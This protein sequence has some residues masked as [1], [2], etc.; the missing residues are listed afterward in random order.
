MF[1]FIYFLKMFF[2]IE[3]WLE[4]WIESLPGQDRKAE[5]GSVPRSRKE[6]E[7]CLEIVGIFKMGLEVTQELG[8]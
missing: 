1:P 5:E 3:M 8:E 2:K 6:F 4:I 7:I